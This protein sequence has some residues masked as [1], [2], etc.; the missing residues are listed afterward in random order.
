MSPAER[1]EST[2]EGAAEPS[3]RTVAGFPSNMKE[4]WAQKLSARAEKLSARAERGAA[5]KFSLKGYSAGSSP[6]PIS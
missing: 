3:A 5:V 4:N 6:F 2:Q 1:P